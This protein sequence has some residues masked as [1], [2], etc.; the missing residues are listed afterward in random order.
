MGL[1]DTLPRT[2]DGKRLL[3][4]SLRRVDR[5]INRSVVKAFNVIEADIRSGASQAVL[6]SSR[7]QVRQLKKLGIDPPSPSEMKKIRSKVLAELDK[8]FPPDQG[9]DFRN[10]LARIERTQVA[11]M[12]EIARSPVKIAGPNAKEGLTKIARGT[13]RTV[14]GSAYK[15]ARRIMIAEETRL[16]NQVEVETLSAAGVDLAYWRLNPGHKWYGGQEVCEHLASRVNPS[17]ARLLARRGVNAALGG[18]N[19]VSRWPAYPHPFCKCYP[20]PF[21]LGPSRRR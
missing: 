8:P 1:I 2:K 7:V 3:A 5:A 14:G 6:R 11:R 4:S 20:E 12:K 10:R 18:L 16:A 21:L 17:V 15:Q 13:T 9:L 19:R